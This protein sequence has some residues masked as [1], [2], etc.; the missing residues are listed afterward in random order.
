MKVSFNKID[1]TPN[2]SCTMAGYSRENPSIGS[3]DPIEINTCVMEI[4]NTPLIF[5]VLDSIM[6]EESFANNIQEYFGNKFNIPKENIVISAIHTHSAP[7]F[8]KLPFEDT[9]VDYKLQDIA[10]EKMIESISIALSS[11][12]DATLNF[13]KTII[14]GIYGNRNEVNGYS[15]KALYTFD[16]IDTNNNLIG[17][18]VNISLHPTILNKSNLYLSADVIGHLRHKLQATKKAP[19][20]I[21]NG[22]CGDVSTRFYRSNSSSNEVKN[23]SDKIFSQISKINTLSNIKLNSL[24]ISYVSTKSYFDANLDDF[25]NKATL[26]LENKLCTASDYEKMYLEMLLVRLRYKASI[27]PFSVNLIS[28]IFVFNNFIFVTLPGDVVSKLGKKIKDSFPD[29]EVILICYSNTYSSYLVDK[30]DY[31]KYFE[32]YNSRV[33]RGEADIF[34]DTIINSTDNLIN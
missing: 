7:A 27:S 16:F 12:Q 21:T 18:F 32:T 11:L 19:V 29:Y 20:V 33:S 6:I 4:N 15:D 3:L 9:K 31:G 28:N 22:T 17:S 1:I 26:E 14:D 13:S 8:F 24:K 2:Y 5:S 23:V 25:N 34:I 30:S 10:Y